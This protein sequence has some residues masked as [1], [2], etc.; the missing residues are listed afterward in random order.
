M[1]N[2]FLTVNDFKELGFILKEDNDCQIYEKIEKTPIYSGVDLCVFTII[3]YQN[4]SHLSVFHQ[5]LKN[6][7]NENEGKGIFYGTIK[8]KKELK[9]LLKQLGIQ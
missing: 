9:V 3:Y 6:K 8:T 7:N 1:K 5:R 4:R 2:K